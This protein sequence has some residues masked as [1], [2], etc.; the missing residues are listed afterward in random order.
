MADM[1]EGMLRGATEVFR[2]VTGIARLTSRARSESW[3]GLVPP[4][5]VTSPNLANE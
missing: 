3:I 2:S 5:A 1:F 4:S